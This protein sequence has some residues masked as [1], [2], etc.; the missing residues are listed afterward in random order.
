MLIFVSTKHNYISKLGLHI[1]FGDS[2]NDMIAASISGVRGVRVVRDP[3]SVKEYSP[4]YFGDTITSVADTDI[5][6]QIETII[7]KQITIK[8]I[9][10][11][12]Y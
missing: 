1:F 12:F 9:T 7:G 8:Q 10:M 11:I 3:R 2:D 4:N 6:S 5:I